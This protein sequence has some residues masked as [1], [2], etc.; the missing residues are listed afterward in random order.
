[1]AYLLGCSKNDILNILTYWYDNSL[2]KNKMNISWEYDFR[3]VLCGTLV[4]S[5]SSDVK[6]KEI[7]NKTPPLI[8]A[9]EKILQDFNSKQSNSLFISERTSSQYR[10]RFEPNQLLD[11][12]LQFMS[13]QTMM[14]LVIDCTE[15]QHTK[16][17]NH[18]LVVDS[19]ESFR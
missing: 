18:L 15:N 1:M 3:L 14:T 8:L 17:H 4:S 6:S 9:I 11:K 5:Y 16:A 10:S 12:L 7:H 19:Y 13:N 2:H